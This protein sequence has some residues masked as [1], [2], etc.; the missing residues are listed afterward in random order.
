MSTYENEEQVV[1][2]LVE[3][4]NADRGGTPAP[5]QT[6]PEQVEAPDLDGGEE[7]T[8]DLPDSF[9]GLNPDDLP[10]EARPFYDSML[11]DYRR[12]TQ[13]AAPWRKLGTELGVEPEA[14]RQAVEFVT[15]LSTDPDFALE[16]HQQLT[17]ALVA[18]GLSPAQAEAE[19]GR[20]IEEAV[21]E[22][23]VDDIESGV[24]S[25]LRQELDELK[26]WREEQEE[27]M[28]EEK[29]NAQ[30]DRMEAQILS[31]NK[32]YGDADIARL[33][34]LSY[35]FGGD[36]V[37]ANEVYKEMRNEAISEY[38]DRKSSPNPVSATNVPQGQRSE[39]AR[40]PYRDLL[41]PGLQREVDEFVRNQ[42]GQ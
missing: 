35:P 16:T 10:A 17:E 2:A 30:L 37:K 34:Q 32:D 8:T 29:L 26:E 1:G 22:T 5:E 21:S 19:A 42:T 6:T 38:I 15:A 25:E 12:K 4:A 3:A 33:Y 36:I 20:Q 7:G 31:E 27:R 28:W 18:A 39:T 9:T 24:D 13:E 14:A 11:A 41:D 23:D 40:E